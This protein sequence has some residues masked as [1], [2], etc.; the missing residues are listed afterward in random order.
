MKL[1]V[2][3][4]QCPAQQNPLDKRAPEIRLEFWRTVWRLRDTFNATRDIHAQQRVLLESVRLQSLLSRHS[5][6]R[7]RQERMRAPWLDGPFESW[8][9]VIR[10]VN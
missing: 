2:F 3:D 9:T 6:T 10:M 5:R 4:P 8:Q 7:S 1:K